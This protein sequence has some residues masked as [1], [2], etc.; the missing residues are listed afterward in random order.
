MGGVELEFD[1]CAGRKRVCSVWIENH[2]V[3]MYISKLT[4]FLRGDE[5]DCVRAENDLVLVYE[6]K[7]TWV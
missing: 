1:L 2:L 4:F 5:I 3:L 6:S 7:L